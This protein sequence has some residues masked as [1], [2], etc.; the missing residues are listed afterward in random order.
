MGGRDRPFDGGRHG[1]SSSGSLSGRAGTGRRT[2]TRVAPACRHRR[3]G[4]RG[5]MRGSGAGRRRPREA[6]RRVNG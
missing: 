5:A 2:S 1:V 3:N 6:G 4:R